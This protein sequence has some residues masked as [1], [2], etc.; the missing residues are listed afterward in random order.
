[1]C[2]KKIV[3]AMKMG[4]TVTKQDVFF[5]YNWRDHATVEAV[6]R[7]MRERGLTPFLDRWYLVPGRPWP[8]ALEEALNNC[9][10]VS[11]FLGRHGMGAWQQR[12]K[13]L[14]LNRQA[15]DSAFQ[16]IQK[17]RL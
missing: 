10:A 11:V 2:K 1:M 12:E 13:D 7:T 8:E 9:Q 15:R 14:A 6:A 3:R 4:G 5:S 17:S 16:V